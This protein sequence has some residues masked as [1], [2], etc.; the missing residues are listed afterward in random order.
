MIHS[1]LIFSLTFFAA[2]RADF[3][4]DK[5][6]NF[7]D[8]A[9]LASEWLETDMSNYAIT[10]TENPGSIT[11]GRSGFPDPHYDVGLSNCAFSF[12]LDLSLISTAEFSRNIFEHYQD[13]GYYCSYDPSTQTLFLDLVTPA[14]QV[15]IP[16]A[17]PAGERWKHVVFSIDRSSNTCV[18]Y[19]NGAAQ[20]PF[21]ISELDQWPIT[22]LTS[23]LIFLQGAP[24]YRIDDFRIYKKTLSAAEVAAIYNGGLGCK[25]NESQAGAA[26]FVMEF[27][28]GQGLPQ[29]TVPSGDNQ[30]TAQVFGNVAWLEDG[31][32][33][34]STLSIPGSIEQA[35]VTRLSALEFN[36]Q[37][38][39]KTVERWSHQVGP[40]KGG[41]ENFTKLKTF[42]LVQWVP[43]KPARHGDYSL[44]RPMQFIVCIGKESKHD[45]V[46]RMGSSA[47][48]GVDKIADLVIAAFDRTH[49]G[50]GI[51][52]DDLHLVGEME[53]VDAPR[54]YAMQ[55]VF[56][57]NY[58]TN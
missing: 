8:F 42:A 50:A 31:V 12:W 5:I 57:C 32:P 14:P 54:Q 3:N 33:F 7:K 2:L 47:E 23:E 34:E 29:T 36:G 26:S 27:D 1:L 44:G 55:L 24:G 17:L 48:P 35:I 28:E 52:S 6:V 18:I 13:G 20:T 39:F 51:L 56:E 11:V 30:I 46:A 25:Y 22:D 58:I 40:E 4:N 19:I 41:L 38:V 10:V 43:A 9:V 49:P 37:K 16:V 53:I 21:D 45:G 15:S